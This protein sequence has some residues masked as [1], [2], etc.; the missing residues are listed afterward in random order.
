MRDQ[1]RIL[2]KKYFSKNVI[3]DTTTLKTIIK[4][5]IYIGN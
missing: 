5:N 2:T 4:N 3:C 1:I